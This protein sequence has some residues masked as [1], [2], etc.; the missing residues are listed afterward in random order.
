MTIPELGNAIAALTITEAEELRRYL[1]QHGGDV[2]ACALVP[3]GPRPPVI[4]ES[5]AGVPNPYYEYM[6]SLSQ[7]VPIRWPDGELLEG[8]HSS[9][10]Q[11]KLLDVHFR[12]PDVRQ[13]SIEST[14]APP[15]DIREGVE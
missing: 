12:G 2:G 7:A 4:F 15:E 14:T 13:F 9:Y 5:V 8:D 11:A 1:E 3:V 10:A 6:R